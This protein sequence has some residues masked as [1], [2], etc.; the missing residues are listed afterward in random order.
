[1]NL[2]HSTLIFTNSIAGI[3]KVALLALQSGI[4]RGPIKAG[5]SNRPNRPDASFLAL[6]AG[7]TGW[8][9]DDFAFLRA[10]QG[11]GQKAGSTG[12]A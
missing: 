10:Q 12:R 4:A 2:L 9:L 8:T 7:K 5:H 1:M 6:L 3:T 11:T